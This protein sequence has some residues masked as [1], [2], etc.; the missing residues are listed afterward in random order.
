M[1]IIRKTARRLGLVKPKFK[2]IQVLYGDYWA[3]KA[4][5]ARKKV[6]LYEMFTIILK[7]YVEEL[8]YNY[9][10]ENEELRK[11]VPRLL[12]IIHQYEEKYGKLFGPLV[13]NQKS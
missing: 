13:K 9:R 6:N 12:A 5:A 2:L 1:G 11:K 4:L 3:F 10:Q 7:Y 8:A